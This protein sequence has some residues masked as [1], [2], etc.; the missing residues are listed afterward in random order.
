MKLS[1]DAKIILA[2]AAI[3]LTLLVLIGYTEYQTAHASAPSGLQATIATTSNPTVNTTAALVIATSSC[4][5]RIITTYA[6]PIMITF[7]DVQ[8]SIPTGLF[9]HLQAA[10]TSI[11]YDS[12]LYGC[13]A[14][15]IYSFVA[16]NIT[17]SDSR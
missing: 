8:G 9:G 5:A 3:V 13:G 15:R 12:G 2:S 4:S 6:S 17:V 11:A 16:Q 1:F 14:V 10:S 7:S